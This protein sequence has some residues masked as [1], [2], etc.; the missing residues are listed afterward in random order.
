MI[1]VARNSWLVDFWRKKVPHPRRASIPSD[2]KKLGEPVEVSSALPRG[3]GKR[4]EGPP[5]DQK[6]VRG[7]RKK[8]EGLSSTGEE[9]RGHRRGGI[10]PSDRQAQPQSC[11]RGERIK[12]E[13][14]SRKA[15]KNIAGQSRSPQNENWREIP[16]AGPME[17]NELRTSFP[18]NRLGGSHIVGRNTPRAAR[19]RIVLMLP[20]ESLN[21]KAIGKTRN[22]EHI[23]ETETEPPSPPSLSARFE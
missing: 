21:I 7:G 17:R 3:R 19:R 12:A 13:I 2:K 11:A 18:N 22:G 1:V 15:N 5:P 23:K 9:N 8:S 14:H 6:G 4:L 10:L 16:D 20:D